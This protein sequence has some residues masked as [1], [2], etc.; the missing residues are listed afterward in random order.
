MKIIL[1]KGIVLTVICLFLLAG[2]S[3]VYAEFNKLTEFVMLLN[4]LVMLM[5]YFSEL[6]VL[7][8]SM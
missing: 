1:S 3:S 4:I 2:L 6:Y 5:V 7:H 8:D